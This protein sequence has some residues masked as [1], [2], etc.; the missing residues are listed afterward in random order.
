MKKN[1]LGIALILFAASTN[2]FSQNWLT[3][4]NNSTKTDTLGSKTNF[5]VGFITNNALRMTITKAGKVG[6]GVKTPT[7]AFQV[8]KTA[9]TDVLVKS[10]GGD[11]N[12]V[13]DRPSNGMEAVTK[14]SQ[15]GV[16]QWKTGLTVNALGTVDYVIKNDVTSSDALTISGSTNSV[17]IP[18][19]YLSL[20]TN[21]TCNIS[22]S[23]NDLGISAVIPGIGFGTPGNINLAVASLYGPAGKVGIGTNDPSKAK[24]VVEGF[25]GQSIA[26]FRRSSNSAGISLAAD[27]PEIYLNSYY[28]SGVKAMKAGYGALIGMDPTSGYI[29]FR[30]GNSAAG[31]NDG[32]LTLSNRMTIGPD[33][34]VLINNSTAN[35]SLNV[36]KIPGTDDAA[37]F[38][39]TNFYSHFAYG[40]NEDTYIRGGIASSNVIIADL[41]NNVGIGTSNPAYKLD[42]CGTMRAKEVRVATGW[43][44]YV[45]ADDYKLPSL[46]D[47]ESFIKT[48]KHLPDVTP[49]SVIEGEGLEVGKTSAQMIKKIEE[50]TLYVIDLQKQVNELKSDKK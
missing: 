16:P 39:G 6:I 9:L 22:K 2:V 13:I 14:Y 42:V 48:N 44:D 26:M 12:V 34:K 8:Q 28:N 29:Y 5:D 21:G 43:C 41:C 27:W 36:T 31:S 3:S 45:F 7:A 32:A 25:V 1:L 11:A 23:G 30:T 46:S 15:T 49:G 33:G 37:S 35:S 4:G 20:G 17:L 10:T 18:S 40:N 50:L 24:L 38:L 19:G 47:V